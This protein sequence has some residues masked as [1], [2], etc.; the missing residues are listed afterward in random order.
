LH[1]FMCS[2][3]CS[4]TFRPGSSRHVRVVALNADEG[5]ARDVSKNIAAKIREVAQREGR[6]LTSWTRAFFEAQPRGDLIEPHPRQAPPAHPPRQI[7][8][9]SHDQSCRKPRNHRSRYGGGRG[10]A[11]SKDPTGRRAGSPFH[12]RNQ[13]DIRRPSRATIHIL[14]RGGIAMPASLKASRMAIRRSV[15]ALPPLFRSDV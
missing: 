14:R 6:D 13:R 11:A 10:R 3:C 4:V 1:D 15:L 8:P 5:W 12:W 7:C 2:T 9:A